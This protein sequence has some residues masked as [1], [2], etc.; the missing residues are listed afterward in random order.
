MRLIVRLPGLDVLDL[1]LST[2][3]APYEDAEEDDCSR[4][5]SGGTLGSDRVDAGPTDWHLGFTN[6]READDG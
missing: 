1:E 6:G 3:S 2:G 5:L 4:D